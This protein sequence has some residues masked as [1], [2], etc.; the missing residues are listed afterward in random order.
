MAIAMA[1]GEDELDQCGETGHQSA[2]FA[3][4]SAAVGEGAARPGMAVVSS[5]KLKM[6]QVYMAATSRCR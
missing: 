3:E 4:G 5:V 2:F 6:K 1:G